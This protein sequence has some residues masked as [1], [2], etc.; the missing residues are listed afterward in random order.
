MEDKLSLLI[1]TFFFLFD[2]KLLLA[3]KVYRF[4]V[5]KFYFFESFW[6][7]GD[8]VKVVFFSC[9]VIVVCASVGKMIKRFHF[10][11]CMCWSI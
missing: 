3:W 2:L 5:E 1:V 4:L 9:D 6:V 11:S 8:H 7:F 10:G